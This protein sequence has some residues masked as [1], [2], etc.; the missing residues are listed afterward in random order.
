MQ[1]A[2]KNIYLLLSII[3]ITILNRSINTFQ[4]TNVPTLSKSMYVYV[5]VDYPEQS[6]SDNFLYQFG[7]HL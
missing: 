6:Q 7:M 5:C 2:Y 4:F 1:L 3:T